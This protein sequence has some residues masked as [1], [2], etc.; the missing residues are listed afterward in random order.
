[1]IG[2]IVYAK[3]ILLTLPEREEG[4][5]DEREN[6]PNIAKLCW[7]L[8]GTVTYLYSNVSGCILWMWLDGSKKRCRV[9]SVSPKM[10][11]AMAS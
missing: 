7:V 2:S 6:E 4:G 3:L 9:M 8:Q 11:R 10:P 5:S 1:M